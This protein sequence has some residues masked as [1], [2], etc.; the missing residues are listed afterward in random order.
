[1]DEAAAVRRAALE[2]VDDV[3]PDRLFER[4]EQRVDGGSTAPGALT[5]CSA[6]AVTEGT[7]AGTDEMLGTDGIDDRAAGV[8]LIYEGLRL[9]RSLSHAEPWAEQGRLDDWST[10]TAAAARSGDGDEKARAAAAA[11]LDVLVADILV[12]R[13]FFLLAR[14][15]AA[16]AAV[17]VVRSFGQDQTVRR[18]TDDSTL[19][20]NLEADVF[21]LAVVAGTTAA[22]GSAPVGCRE[23][24]TD[25]ATAEGELPQAEAVLTAE[26]RERLGGLV[27]T[28]P[29]PAGG[30]R[31]SADH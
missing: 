12:A 1:M 14:T 7:S 6:A 19:D 8:Q 13:G 22:G 5:L 29:S 27:G 30:A 21:E 28:D 18:E 23:F 4:I 16:D 9:T 20:G 25:L 2:A 17:A 26:V 24:V 11:D 10:T 31:T 3:D 15:E